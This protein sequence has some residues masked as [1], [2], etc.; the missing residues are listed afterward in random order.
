M[1]QSSLDVFK[2]MAE[3]NP[4]IFNNTLPQQIGSADMAILLKMW[5]DASKQLSDINM[6]ALTNLFYAQLK[7]L[8]L[9]VSGPALQDLTDTNTTFVNSLVQKQ[10]AMVS[11]FINMFTNN[12]SDLQKTQGMNDIM[13]LQM[14]FFG[15]LENKFKATSADL[16]QL[17]Q[18][19]QTA[20][21]NLTNKTLEN[22]IK[23]DGKSK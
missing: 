22:T 17:L 2:K 15:D 4:M 3:S 19:A 20:T 7:Q 23:S 21:T 5:L 8:N 6:A 16:M 10:M 18:S 9:G 12:L 11:D 14:S 13:I 1:G